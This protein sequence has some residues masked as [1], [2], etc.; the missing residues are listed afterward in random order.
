VNYFKDLFGR[1]SQS[2]R[3]VA[4][5]F[6]GTLLLILIGLAWTRLPEKHLWQVV[7]TFIVPV[8]AAISF[9]ELNAGTMRS[10]AGDDGK[11][12]K[13]VWGAVT[14]L[15]WFA[16][17]WISWTILDWCD[18][19]SYQ[20]ASYLNS[21]APAHW[22]AR[23]FT[24]DHLNHW[25]TILIWIFRWIVVPA[26]VIPYAIASAQSGYRMP[27]RRVLQ[28]L[29]NWRWWSAVVVA[30]LV[31][32]WL[33]SLMFAPD[34]HG[35]L[36][37]Q[38]WRVSLKL[39]ETY[40]LA[41]ISWVLLLAWAA[42]LFARQ[43]PLPEND[44]L[45]SLFKRLQASRRWVGAQF[46]WVLITVPWCEL[47]AHLA[48]DRGWLMAILMLP[49]LAALLI[50]QTSLLR[51]LINADEMRVSLIWGTIAVLAWVIPSY[52]ITLN[53]GKMHN[54]VFI[55]VLDGLVLPA[56]FIPLAGI[57]ASWGWRVKWRRIL[58]LLCNWRWWLGAL[59][60]ALGRALVYIVRDEI[61]LTQNWIRWLKSE[62]TFLLVMGIW[63]LL[64]GWFAVPVGPEQNTVKLPLPESE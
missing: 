36:S 42:V 45:T 57:A 62:V 51:S 49:V 63:I 35:T 60:A 48:G 23:L 9:L 34:P 24:Y 7:L 46:I 50:L 13:L 2:R 28:L 31:G 26:K 33:P 39:A 32:V 18:A 14:L 44:A 8:L 64:L 19:Q 5:Q 21:Q 6:I 15:F 1:L 47:A 53:L 61:V 41:M 12:V 20:W 58:S 10:L 3:W 52:V 30:A 40:L 43:K 27:W 4:A 25:I 55:W 17:V 29:W 38:I 22:R 56:F 54:S 59:A 37:A 11:R 16:V